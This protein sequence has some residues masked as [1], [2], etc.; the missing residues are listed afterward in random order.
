MSITMLWKIADVNSV[1]LYEKDE[2][3]QDKKGTS[4]LRTFSIFKS[5][6]LNNYE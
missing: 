1:V 6:F 3:A 5:N 2:D 4:H